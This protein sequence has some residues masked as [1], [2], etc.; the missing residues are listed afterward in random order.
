MKKEKKKD[1]RLKKNWS[2][3]RMMSILYVNGICKYCGQPKGEPHKLLREDG[4][5]SQ[6]WHGF[7]EFVGNIKIK[8]ESK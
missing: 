4:K 2:K 6:Y 5:T 7:D 3:E 1:M 8:W